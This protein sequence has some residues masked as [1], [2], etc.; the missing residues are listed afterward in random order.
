MPYKGLTKAGVREQVRRLVS[1]GRIRWTLHIE[2][3]MEVRHIA[4]DEVK[5]CLLLGDFEEE[6]TIPNRPGDIEY[7]FRMRANV[8]GRP[9]AV[10]ASLIPDRRVVTIT[11]FEP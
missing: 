6:P 8:E 1:E 7:V 2:Q 4:K 9:L 10:A 3:Q 11:V 5:E